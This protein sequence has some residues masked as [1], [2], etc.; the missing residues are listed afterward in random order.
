MVL[1]SRISAAKVCDC[2]ISAWCR[3]AE[4]TYVVAWL[5]CWTKIFCAS[6]K[7]VSSVFNLA[8]F[9]LK[10]QFSTEESWM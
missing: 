1:D 10:N 4:L 7:N 2:V 5:S 6:H 8:D 3:Q 9:A